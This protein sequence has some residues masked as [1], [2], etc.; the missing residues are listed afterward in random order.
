MSLYVNHFRAAETTFSML[1]QV[2]GRSGRGAY[3]G[4]A[5][6]QTMT[7]DHTVIKMAA[8]QDYDS[9]YDLEHTMRYMQKSPP[10]GDL[11]TLTF[12]SHLEELALRGAYD[13]GVMLRKLQS[14]CDIRVLGP[15]PAPVLKVNY[16]Y[17][18]RLTVSCKNT[19]ELRLQI[20]SLMKLFAKDKR[21]KGVNVFADVNSYE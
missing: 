11:I 5:I 14:A 9:F 3:S 12:M 1:T 21:Y 4:K 18:Y 10:C 2:I 17:R 16:T 19:R 6:I 20:S 13:F 7:P 8:Q 15:I